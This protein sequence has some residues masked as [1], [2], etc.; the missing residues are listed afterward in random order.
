MAVSFMEALDQPYA[1]FL[2]RNLT[3]LASYATGKLPMT[4]PVE[5]KT[6]VRPTVIYLQFSFGTN[7]REM[8]TMPDVV[9]Q[10]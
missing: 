7:A 3:P 4:R 6:V 10:Y 5:I 1:V 8:S 9:Q 2:Q